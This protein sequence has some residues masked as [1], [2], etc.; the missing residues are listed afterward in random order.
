MFCFSYF[1]EI[2]QSE[3]SL[4]FGAANI[5]VTASCYSFSYLLND[6][7]GLPA[8]LKGAFSATRMMS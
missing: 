2:N 7:K 6:R 1:V 3:Y 5:P 4:L 8:R